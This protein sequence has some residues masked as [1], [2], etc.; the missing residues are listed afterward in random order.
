MREGT[1]TTGNLAGGEAQV[2]ARGGA[3]FATARVT[4]RWTASTR[5]EGVPANIAARFAAGTA[6]ATN[7]PRVVYPYDGTLFPPNLSTLEIQWTPPAGAGEFYDVAFTNAATDV[8]LYTRCTRVGTGCG[9]ALDATTW[10]WIAQTNRGS[11]QPL[12]VCVRAMLGSG[13]VGSSD[14]VRL[15]FAPDEVEGGIY[16]TAAAGANG[17]YR[18]DFTRGDRAPQPYFTKMDTPPIPRSDD[19]DAQHPCTG[20]HTLS[21]DGTRMATVL[22]WRPLAPC[23]QRAALS[24][25]LGGRRGGG[26]GWR[27]VAGS[28]VLQGA[29]DGVE[30]IVDLV[31]LLDGVVRPALLAAPQRVVVGSPGRHDHLDLGVDLLEGAEGFQTVHAWHLVV[32]DRHFELLPP[33]CLH[34][35][36]AALRRGDL[37]A[38]HHQQRGE[39]VANAGLVVDG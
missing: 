13:G 6:D 5:T 20:C 31:G 8:H 25:G 15:R 27:S 2:V 28:A 36:H 35:I 7:R 22:D 38:F 11:A 16:W 17:I 10:R 12:E 26:T 18:Y 3:L 23:A 29:L 30:Q 34:R 21:G 33:S 14:S 32:G 24:S 19:G 37:V 9:A 4:V 1:F 39:H